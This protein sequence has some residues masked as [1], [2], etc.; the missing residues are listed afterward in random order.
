MYTYKR[1]VGINQ[2]IPKGEELLDISAQIVKDLF[3]QYSE[4]V[5]VV[6]DAFAKRD[7]AIDLYSYYNELVG[8]TGTIQAW[9]DTKTTVPLISSNTLPGAEYRFV[10]SHDIQYEWFSLLPGDIRISADRQDSLT[11]VSAPDIRVRKTDQTAV[12]YTALTKR[13]L[14]TVNNHLVRAI[15][16]E[17]YVFLLNAGKHFNVNDNIHVGYLNFNTVSTLNTYPV[18]D[19]QIDF[20]DHDTYQSLRI[21]TP[22]EL[23]NKTVWM[24]IGGRLCLADVVQ[25]NGL[26]GV[27]VRLERIEWFKRIF[28][29]KDWIDLEGVI[30]QEREVVGKDFFKTEDFFRKLMTHPSTFLIVLDNPN[31]YVQLEP[32]KTYRYPFTFHTHETRKIPLLVSSGLLP[33]YFSRKIINRRLLDIDIGVNK[34]YLNETTGVNN[35]GDL[36]HSFTNRFLPSTLQQGYL[37]YIRGLIQEK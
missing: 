29:S 13:G 20:E 10:T 8:Y 23:A 14:W 32:L 1:A 3:I 7:V 28:E 17:E 22:L 27:T 2:L 12:D 5:I 11:K 26:H 30:D 25:V 31:M 21:N 33:K 15:E 4:L 24:S 36:Y 37:L 18:A 19:A 16:G 9:L 34:K 35:G 6:N